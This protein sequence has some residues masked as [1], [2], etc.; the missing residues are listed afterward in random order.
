MK[1]KIGFIAIGQA[2][3]NIG[4]L[5]EDRG[6]CVLY[7]NTSK[8]DLQTLK[9]VK[10]VYHIS[11]G[12]G[13][14]KD[15][16]KAKQLVIDDFDNISK[17][18]Y[19]KMDVSMV[20]VI[21]SSGGG[22]GS[23]CGPMLIDLLL[24]DIADGVAGIDAVGAVTVLPGEKESVKAHI[25]SYECLQELTGIEEIAGTVIIDNAKGD[26]LQ[27]NRRFANMFHN[28]LEIPRL[29]HDE[30]GN[31]DRAEIE[32]TLKAKGMLVFAE[33]PADKASTAGLLES[34]KQS[35]FA[36]IE[37]DRVIKY[38]T[39]SIA[40]A[41]NVD[42][43]RKDIGVPVDVFCTY[44]DKAVLCCLSGL[45]YPVTRMEEIFR[46]ATEHQETILKNLSATS[47][48][49]MKKGVNFLSA[50]K[51][52]KKPVEHPEKKVSRRELMKRY[53]NG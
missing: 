25:N 10:Y 51:K 40:G 3:G 30:R 16:C 35:I 36:P 45:N 33:L 7:L 14:N 47:E 20:F 11:G 22:T 42:D 12:E 15:R 24:G 39:I 4:K 13:C 31:I 17:E 9:N 28:F 1:K 44:N 53:F 37:T 18:I 34:F 48:N 49:G 5:F 41:V 29:H 8:E 21:F 27:L 6:Y 52:A 19:E 23:G 2:G 43:M 50:D 26:K 38:V 46:R 32:E